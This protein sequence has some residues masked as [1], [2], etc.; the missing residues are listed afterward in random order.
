MSKKA[1]KPVPAKKR[2]ESAK[3]SGWLLLVFSLPAR[4][5]SERVGVWRKLKKIGAL[6]L[7]PPG[8]LLPR[9]PQ[10]QEH[11]EWLAASIR[12]Y[13]GQA[14]VIDVRAIDDLPFTE[15]VR[16]FNQARSRE[17][18]ELMRQIA[19]VSHKKRPATAQIARLRQRLL[20]IIAIDFFNC[21]LRART[22]DLL[23]NATGAKDGKK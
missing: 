13:K 18:E 3:D 23:L 9:N 10:N 17:Y 2:P 5:T 7:G 22:E 14:S 21:G 12:G 6:P 15:L 8:Y 11:F 20:E 19:Q 4:R 1:A 16:R